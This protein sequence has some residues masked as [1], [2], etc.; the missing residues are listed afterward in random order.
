VKSAEHK[1]E[2]RTGAMRDFYQAYEHEMAEARRALAPVPGQAGALVYLSGR[3]VG[4]DLLAGPGLFARTWP[5]LCAGYAADG[6]GRKPGARLM[7][8][9]GSVL[10]ALSR[11]PSETAPVV[12]LGTEYR[13]TG[14]LAGA[15]LVAEDRVAHLMAFPGMAVR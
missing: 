11:C 15:A 14:A 2:S 10:R 9:P 4:M 7:R 1:V 6:I 5:R 13:L 12:G 3:W 8:S